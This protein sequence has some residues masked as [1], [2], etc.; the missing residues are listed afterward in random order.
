MAP[1]TPSDFAA[2]LREHALTTYDMVNELN[3][4]GRLIVSE[5]LD[6]IDRLEAKLGASHRETHMLRAKVVGLV[7]VLGRLERGR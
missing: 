3:S 2:R 5:L 6:K 1:S 4:G 7:E